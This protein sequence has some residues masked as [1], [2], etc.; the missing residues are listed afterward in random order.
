MGR[1][2][3]HA[4]CGSAELRT[5]EK[6]VRTVFVCL[7]LVSAFPFSCISKTDILNLTQFCECTTVMHAMTQCMHGVLAHARCIAQNAELSVPASDCTS[8]PSKSHRRPPPPPP[9]PP[10]R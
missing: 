2:V 3:L 4:N 6:C 7:Y 10:A 1:G 8:S 9:P 5:L